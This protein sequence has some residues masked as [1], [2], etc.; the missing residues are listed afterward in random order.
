MPT[1][2]HGGL[3]FHYLDQSSNAERRPLV[4]FVIQHGIGGTVRQPSSLMVPLPGFVRLVALDSRGHGETRPTAQPDT[5]R[6]ETYADDVIAL[7]DRLDL[8]RAVVGGISMGAGI[9]LNLAL[10]FPERVAGLVLSRP[11]WLAGPMAAEH[12]YRQIAG[13]LRKAGPVEGRKMFAATPEYQKVEAVSPDAAKSL[14][15]QFDEPR[16][17]EDVTRLE[18]LSADSPFSLLADLRTIQA[19]TLVLATDQ[20]PVHPLAYGRVLARHVPKARFLETTS[21]SK[22]PEGH[23][24]EMRQ[25]IA[26]FLETFLPQFPVGS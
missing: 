10:R 18:F 25:A 15:G 26:S 16:A 2:E 13:L 3:T 12:L 1:F 17:L 4:P 5:L 19:P 20:D 11:A 21:K 14:L 23:Q 7:M 24:H 8:S 22:S 6:F 9:A